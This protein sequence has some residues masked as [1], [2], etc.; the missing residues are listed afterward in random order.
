MQKIRWFIWILGIVLML[1]VV[2]QNNDP[3]EVQLLWLEQSMPL[4]VMLL[5]TTAVG[6]LLGA[7]FTVSMIRKQPRASEE[8]A[9]QAEDLET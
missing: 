1:V 8:K 7:L 6:F 5:I 4:S 9:S 3:T 2:L